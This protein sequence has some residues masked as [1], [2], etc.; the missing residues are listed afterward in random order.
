MKSN[1]MK[2]PKNQKL[3]F[4]SYG[5]FKPG[6]IPYLGIK[7]YALNIQ[8]FKIPGEILIRDG[9]T[10]YKDNPNREVEGF[11]IN[12]EES[13]AEDAYEYIA[14]LE[15]SKIYRWECKE[16]NGRCFNILCGVSPEKGSQ[17]IEE[18]EWRSTW[19]DP[20]FTSAI[21]VLEELPEEPFDW[22][23]K[24]TFKLQMKYLL[25]WTIIERF[26]FLRYSFKAG[27]AER[28][29]KLAQ[30]PYF[31]EGL[32]LFCKDTRS[33]YSTEDPTEKF[34]LDTANSQKS[35][36]Y[37]YKVRCNISH[38]GKAVTKDYDTVLSSYREL[39]Q[40]TKYILFKTRSE[41][42]EIKNDNLI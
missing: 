14:S 5:I 25:L 22:E 3:P 20:Y 12:F 16:L 6:E 15:P 40:I 9:V 13:K 32:K 41:C 35:I 36:Q 2:P 33:V 17:N 24:S 18:A 26:E 27:P 37:F 8:E 19:E 4:F 29:K 34:I 30:N 28:N 11:L 10:I 21:S 1:K 38:R 31:I 7:E 39:F 42:D 23:M